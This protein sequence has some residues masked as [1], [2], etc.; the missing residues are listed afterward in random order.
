M[1][2]VDRESS[3]L[4]NFN[5]INEKGMS[6]YLYMSYSGLGR[7]DEFISEHAAYRN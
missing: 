2:L 7:T 5:K 3:D 4:E 6:F 1:S